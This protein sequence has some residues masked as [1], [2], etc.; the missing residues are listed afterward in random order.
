MVE[1]AH[2]VAPVVLVSATPLPQ[3]AVEP[4]GLNV[5]VWLGPQLA[6]ACGNSHGSRPFDY[7]FDTYTQLMPRPCEARPTLDCCCIPTSECEQRATSTGR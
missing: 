2:A 4:S 6:N 7:M 3:V 5:A 1:R